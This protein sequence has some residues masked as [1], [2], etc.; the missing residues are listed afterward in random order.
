MIMRMACEFTVFTGKLSLTVQTAVNRRIRARAF[1]TGQSALRLRGCKG[2]I[3][4]AATI[5]I[6]QVLI[7]T[8]G[9]Q[10][11]NVTPLSLRH[12]LMIIGGTSIV[13]WIGELVR[14]VIKKTRMCTA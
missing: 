4:I 7:V 1:L 13:L 3:F 2:F 5:F 10:M 6:G 12:W 8:F 9:G 11:F 14:L